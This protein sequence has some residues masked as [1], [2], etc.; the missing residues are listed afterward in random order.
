MPIGFGIPQSQRVR[1]AGQFHIQRLTLRKR[2]VRMCLKPGHGIVI[3][4]T[5]RLRPTQHL[6]L[7]R[8]LALQLVQRAQQMRPAAL[9]LAG[10]LI[11][12]TIEVAHQM[13][14][15]LAIQD[16]LEHRLSAAVVILIVAYR[17]ITWRRESPDVAV[18]TI[19][20]PTCFVA[21]QNWA[22]ACGCLERIDR[23]LEGLP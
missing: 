3:A 10:I 7:E 12:A 14:R 2:R 13:A 6:S 8:V 19:F 15:K 22:G 11:V 23:C 20:A 21:V 18:L 9:M 5:Y 16:A 17:I 1:A 4:R